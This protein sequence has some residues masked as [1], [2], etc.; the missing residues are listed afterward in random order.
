MPI[1]I[2]CLIIQTFYVAQADLKLMTPL[3]Y[4][5]R[6]EI[7]GVHPIPYSKLVFLTFEYLMINTKYP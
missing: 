4:F 5:P 7:T 3:L 1:L 2:A 6:A